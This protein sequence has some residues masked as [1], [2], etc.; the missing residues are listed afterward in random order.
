MNSCRI[1]SHF[2]SLF[3]INFTLMWVW[4]CVGVYV[5]NN[6]KTWSQCK[7]CF[8]NSKFSSYILDYFCQILYSL[9][10]YIYIYIYIYIYY[11]HNLWCL[12]NVSFLPNQWNKWFPCVG[13]LFIYCCVGHDGKGN[14]IYIAWLFTLLYWI[15]FTIYQF[16]CSILF[17]SLFSGGFIYYYYYYYLSILFIYFFQAQSSGVVEYTDCISAKY[18]RYDTK[19][20][21][22]EAPVML[23]LW[24]M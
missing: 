4:V 11:T 3:S 8:S 2:N 6:P 22:D 19:Q 24:G 12:L 18:P 21:D 17:N 7:N 9:Q 20:S 16:T 14:L 1:F 5:N 15:N 10:L 23:E 13:H